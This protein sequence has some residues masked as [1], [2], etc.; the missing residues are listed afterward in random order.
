M[1]RIITDTNIW[2]E[3]NKNKIREIHDRNYQL[4]IPII[5][6]N[7]LGTSPNVYNSQKSFDK[8]KTA[9]NTISENIE[10]IKFLELNPFEYLIRNRHPNISPKGDVVHHLN[11]LKSISELSYSNLKEN[12]NLPQRTDISGLTNFINTTSKEYKKLINKNKESK[13]NF[14]E[15]DTIEIT[16]SLLL[17]Y[18][19]DNLE[20]M[21]ATYPK[22]NTIEEDYELLLYSFD[23]LLREVSKTNKKIEDNDWV[24]LFNLTY[25]G[26]DDL[27]WTKEISKQKLIMGGELKKHDLRRYLYEI[28][29]KLTKNIS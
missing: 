23:N 29:A 10:N 24:D 20:I 26:K 21:N 5:L 18:I 11:V 17:K 19:N 27:Y 22:I 13:S 9:V 15:T 25:V 14:D 3:L 28:N 7:E 6:L 2:Y 1:K 8:F 4:V 12:F 16:E